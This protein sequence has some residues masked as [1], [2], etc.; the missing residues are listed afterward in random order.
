V[1]SENLKIGKEIRVIK[2]NRL[3]YVNVF[4]GLTI[5][6]MILV[7][8]PSSWFFVYVPLMHSDRHGCTP[9]NLVFPFFLFIMGTTMS[10]SLGSL[11]IP[12][13]IQKIP[14]QVITSTNDGVM[15]IQRYK[16]A[17]LE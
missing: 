13:E 12:M 14:I 3:L 11:K 1:K 16:R 7:S 4:R 8:T 9:T 17:H 15:I 5:A 6:L 10:Y 2:K